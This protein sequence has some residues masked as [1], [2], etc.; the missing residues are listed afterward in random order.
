[1]AEER[2]SQ[3]AVP[4]GA[5]AEAD[6]QPPAEAQAAAAEA[7]PGTTTGSTDSLANM[8]PLGAAPAMPSA[9][10]QACPVAKGFRI[11]E[12]HMGYEYYQ[13]D[14]LTN[15]M[16]V[17]RCIRG[18]AVN[19]ARR[20]YLYRS[21]DGHWIASESSA[22]CDDP[23]NLGSPAFRTV[24]EVE[25]ISLPNMVQWQWFDEAGVWKGNMGFNT[26]GIIAPIAQ[27][28]ARGST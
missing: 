6:T 21:E 11:G 16:P 27:E 17:Y 14:M 2:G 12:P 19:A 15:G 18:T 9:R 25:D 4:V 10:R 1:M 5:N 22:N 3:K 13:T 7:L 23:V 28:E 24:H 26:Y 20:L 8:A